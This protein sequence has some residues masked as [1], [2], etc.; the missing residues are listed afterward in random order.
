MKKWFAGSFIFCDA[1][2][3]RAVGGFSSE[4]FVSE[5]LDLSIRLK[6]YG[7]AQGKRVTILSR[8]PLVTSARKVK[9]YGH[10][11]H[12]KFLFKLILGRNRVIRQRE[13]CAIWYDGKR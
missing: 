13:E 10:R 5:E 4:L 7:Q 12:L 9:L 11:A 1:R 6:A 2:A 8:H 3:F